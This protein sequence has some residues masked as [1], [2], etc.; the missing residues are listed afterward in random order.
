LQLS[1]LKIWTFVSA[2]LIGSFIVWNYA[3]IL[4]PFGVVG[5]VL[6]GL[7]RGIVA[8]TRRYDRRPPD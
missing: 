7:T 6:A 5:L 2:G 4:I 8:L 1:L 3:P